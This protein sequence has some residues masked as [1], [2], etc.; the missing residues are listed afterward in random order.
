MSLAAIKAVLPDYWGRILLVGFAA[1]L[2][3]FVA[4]DWRRAHVEKLEAEAA[5]IAITAER[6]TLIRERNAELVARAQRA[7]TLAQLSAD[8]VEA[9][10]EVKE[11]MEQNKDWASQ[12]LPDALRQR[13]AR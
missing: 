6:D 2:V 9:L 5:V 4:Y 1:I 8:Q 12:P 3:C 7:E 10:A 13:L 11:I